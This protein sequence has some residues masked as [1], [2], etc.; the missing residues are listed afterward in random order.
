MPTPGIVR[1][2]AMHAHASRVTLPRRYRH[3]TAGLIVHGAL[4]SRQRHR[5][6]VA[7]A[8]ASALSRRQ[9]H[10]AAGARIAGANRHRDIASGPVRRCACLDGYFSRRGIFTTARFESNIPACLVCAGS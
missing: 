2:C 1:L 7:S 10:R 3:I 9:R 6:T 5:A 8:G 4:T